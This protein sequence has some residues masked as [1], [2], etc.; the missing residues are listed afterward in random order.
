MSGFDRDEL[1]GS[2]QNIV[3]HPDMPPGVF[4]DMWRTSRTA[5]PERHRQKPLQN[6]DHYWVNAFYRAHFGTD[7]QTV[8]YMSVR[9]PA[10]RQEIAQAGRHQKL[11]KISDQSNGEASVFAVRMLSMG[12]TEYRP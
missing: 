5:T 7:G 11:G 6:G 4:A 8:G 12:V 1:I 9:S 2:S 10:S 3:R